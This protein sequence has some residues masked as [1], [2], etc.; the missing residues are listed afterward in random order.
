MQFSMKSFQSAR[1]N[2]KV[3]GTPKLRHRLNNES[4]ITAGLKPRIKNGNN[5]SVLMGSQ[6][7]SGSL[8]HHERS[9][10][11][12]HLEKAFASLPISV[13]GQGLDYRIF[14]MREGNFIDDDQAT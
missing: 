8:R 11:Y 6:K 9:P 3:T 1:Y 7:T 2:I 13:L 10:S 5:A 4:P 14:W 12:T